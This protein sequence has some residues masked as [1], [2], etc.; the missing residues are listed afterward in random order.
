MADQYINVSDFQDRYKYNHQTDKLLDERSLSV[1][2]ALDKETGKQVVF[3]KFDGPG[4]TPDVFLQE[5][6]KVLNISHPNLISHLNFWIIKTENFFGEETFSYVSVHE[7]AD[8]LNLCNWI[9]ED[10]KGKKH[11]NA[12]LKGILEGLEKLHEEGITHGNL[13]PDN[14]IILEKEKTAIPVLINFG[15]SKIFQAKKTSSGNLLLGTGQYL[16]PE[17]ILSRSDSRLRY[18]IDLWA[19]G[20]ILYEVLAGKSPFGSKA[21]GHSLAFIF[22]QILKA[23]LTGKIKEFDQPYQD[24]VL[25]C[26]KR[27]PEER[28]Q[29]PLDLMHYLA[30]DEEASKE[31]SYDPP[32]S[33]TTLAGRV[34]NVHRFQSDLGLDS[35]DE[36]EL[37]DRNLSKDQ[38]PKY[39]NTNLAR[40]VFLGQKDAGKSTL[41]NYL[42]P[43]THYEG[44][45]ERGIEITSYDIHDPFNEK[46][47]KVNLWEFADDNIVHNTYRFFLSKEIVYVLVLT[48]ETKGNDQDVMNWL[49]LIQVHGEN[50]QIIVVINKADQAPS[51]LNKSTLMYEFP[52][53]SDWVEI[54][55]NI[56]GDI[57]LLKEA[58]NHNIDKL[59][60]I[61]QFVPETWLSIARE[62]T[63]NSLEFIE[64]SVFRQIAQKQG[65]Q[66][67]EQ[68]DLAAW[69]H[70]QGVML[71]FPDKFALQGIGILNPEWI[72][73][74]VAAIMA[75]P[76]IEE[77]MGII[78]TNKLSK[79]LPA[80]RFPREKHIVLLELMH[81]FQF[82]FPVGERLDYYLIPSLLP[83]EQPRYA[84]RREGSQNF[85][86]RYTRI[87]QSLIHR[88][89]V[90]MHRYT[91]ETFIWRTG[92]VLAKSE[93]RAEIIFNIDINSI[94]IR[95]EGPGSESLFYLVE[96]KLRELHEQYGKI[97]YQTFVPCVCAHC[98]TSS[99]PRFYNLKTLEGLLAN[100]ATSVSCEKGL[101]NISISKLIKITEKKPESVIEVEEEYHNNFSGILAKTEITNKTEKILFLAS[102]PSDTDDLQLTIELKKIS[103]GLQMAKH[104]DRFDLKQEWA[105]TPR[106]FRLAI[107]NNDPVF[108]HFSGHGTN[109]G[110]L[111]AESGTRNLSWEDEEEAGG[112]I[113]ENDQGRATLVSGEML[114]SFFKIFKS[115]K[116]VLLNACH[117]K[118]QAEAISKHIQYVI[119]M[120][121]PIKDS[122]AIS[123]AVEFYD[124][125]G[126]GREIE[127]AFDY[128]C[129]ALVDLNSSDIPVLFKDGVII[130]Q[131]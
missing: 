127:F 57:G 131:N 13:I 74:G 79:I 122:A 114:E 42:T 109:Q 75:V 113:L 11:L 126:A 108:V 123:F 118:L 18:N 28:V 92:V 51:L 16:A 129:T 5:S 71:S 85:R 56:D 68:E 22:D 102:N 95:V 32:T 45:N 25:Q 97:S 38:P 105:V 116:C 39:I 81:K 47:I 36:S 7:Y 119:G 83:T 34:R 112:L 66:P 117:S 86:L 76:E 61:A 94:D 64:F 26:L 55:S 82:C 78:P 124:A 101:T 33:L 54:S 110:E 115:I 24:I 63:A 99:D 48:P 37:E 91:E 60:H 53:I 111:D 20:V 67:A 43:E 73:D 50:S 121:R 98:S 93:A 14:I 89:L 100:K 106:E 44:K 9:E 77:K 69:L 2:K 35:T 1:F 21:E 30:P 40:V 27:D 4:I 90:R 96:T 15:Y 41:I 107:L 65:L 72:T 58:I 52:Q 125:I 104:R 6:E 19:F 130:S 46:N 31:P 3:Q 17:K 23:D 8:G 70:S 10:H 128:A 80:N 29:S 49:N 62:L 103:K 59:T 120:K 88:F 84:W 12:I 87:P